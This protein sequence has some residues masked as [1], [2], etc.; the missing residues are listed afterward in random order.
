MKRLISTILLG[1]MFYN[2]FGYYLAYRSLIFEAKAEMKDIIR[3]NEESDNIVLIKLP[4]IN[5]E[6]LDK[7]FKYV[8]KNEFMYEGMM[9]DIEKQEI[10]DGYIFFYCI[11]DTKE[12]KINA[13][14][15]QHI[16]DNII[17]FPMSHKK[18]SIEKNSI[19]KYL[20]HYSITKTFPLVSLYLNSILSEQVLTLNLDNE[21]P[22]PRFI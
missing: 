14:L 1:L 9:Y 6:I 4:Y 10:Y 11:N 17:G 2:I 22:P 13:Q 16:D 5:G 3:D 7:N 19:Q 15:Y 12:E 8:E 21:T 18:S 20:P